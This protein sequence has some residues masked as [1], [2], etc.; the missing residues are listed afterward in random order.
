MTSSREAGDDG[1]A[2]VRALLARDPAAFPDPPALAAAAGM[3]PE[4]LE[5]VVLLHAHLT[6]AALLLRARVAAARRRL[7]ETAEPVRDAGVAAGFSS[8]AAFERALVAAT[9]LTPAAY[10]AL[11]DGPAFVLRLP[12]GYRTED[13]LGYHGRDADGVSER[14]RANGIVKPL[15]LPSGRVGVLTI[16]LEPGAA[17]CALD[18]GGGAC[19][20]E[21]TAY[22]HDVALRMLGLDGDPAAFERS[23][24][25]GDPLRAHVAKRTGLRI[26]RTATVF[27]SLAWAIV[28]QQVHLGFAI[29][30]R[31]TLCTLAGHAAPHGL[32]THPRASD[33][34]ALDPADLGRARFSRAKASTLVDTA[35]E[36]GDAPIEAL[37]DGS[38]LDARATLIARRGIGPWTANY[39]LMRGCGFADSLPLGDA[40]LRAAL[41]RLHGLAAGPDPAQTEA[42]MAPYAPFRTYATAHL[43]A[44]LD[45]P[46]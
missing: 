40:G 14:V 34:A 36:L 39:V 4:A 27:E 44:S 3:E 8:A 22:A 37:P 35:R 32:R 1:Y 46:A 29:K 42:L 26:P 43:W 15:M 38:A 5:R 11:R 33:V 9:G 19:G 31:R 41:R 7:L 20:P 28:G 24:A 25:D 45:D 23:L 10:R 13:P 2:A 12:A 30:L 18:V 16:E 6:P 17:R 21:E